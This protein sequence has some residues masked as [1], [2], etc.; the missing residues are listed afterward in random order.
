M[1]QLI[2]VAVYCIFNVDTDFRQRTKGGMNTRIARWGHSLAVRIPKAFAEEAKLA[3]GTEVDI[4]VSE[5]RLVISPRPDE[6]SL[7]EL[8]ERIT[9]E[10][11]HEES[12]WGAPAGRE[13]W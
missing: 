12:D 9:P 8:V 13:T 11:R 4:A 6:P 1:P 10:N 2:V 5:G 3:E 7:E